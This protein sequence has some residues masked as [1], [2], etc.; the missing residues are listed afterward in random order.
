MCSGRDSIVMGPFAV[1]TVTGK[2]VG[3][4]RVVDG[5][6]GGSLVVVVDCVPAATVVVV[7]GVYAVAD[8]DPHPAT[9]SANAAI[10]TRIIEDKRMLLSL[11]GALLYAA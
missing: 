4:A 6:D 2:P 9:T 11:G 1:S 7:A 5:L 8:D 3:S 10:A